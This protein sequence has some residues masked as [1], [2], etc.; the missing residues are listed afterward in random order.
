[1]LIPPKKHKEP[2]APNNPSPIPTK[3]QTRS[4]ASE[5]SKVEDELVR[6]EKELQY[7]RD[8]KPDATQGEALKTPIS[9]EE[10]AKKTVKGADS[11]LRKLEEMKKKYASGWNPESRPRD[12]AL[13]DFALTHEA[14]NHYK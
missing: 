11:A 13:H 3:M 14:L 2:V 5:E 1:M 6:R 10:F 8:L 9:G 12:E 4:M 7:Y